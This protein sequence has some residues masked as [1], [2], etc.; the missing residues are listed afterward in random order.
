MLKGHAKFLAPAAAVPTASCLDLDDPL[1]VDEPASVDPAEI[2]ETAAAGSA[3]QSESATEPS[4]HDAE[5][6][7]NTWHLNLVG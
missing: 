7:R 6:I 3:S 2:E 5:D 1:T 4:N